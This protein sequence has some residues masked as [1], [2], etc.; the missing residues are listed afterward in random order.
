MCDRIGRWT[1][2]AGALAA[3]C[4]LL[5]GTALGS[6]EPGIL[7]TW[8]IPTPNSLPAGIAVLS[9]GAV[10]FAEAGSDRIGRLEPAT[11][12]ITEWGV[13]DGP[14]GLAVGPGD[15]IYFTERWS[16]RIGRIYPAAGFYASESVA[17]SG[18]QPLGLAI[19]TSAGTTLWWSELSAGKVGRL[20]A[21]GLLFDVLL[22]KVPTSQV[23]PPVTTILS[24]TTTTVFP[25]LVPGNPFL[26]PSI[27]LAPRTGS[28][29]YAEW[30]IPAGGFQLRDLL[31]DAG[32]KI[33]IS[34][35]TTSLLEL[36]PAS[37]T[38]LYHDLP[39][40]SASLK[41][42]RD[43]AGRI[44]F[45]GSWSDKLGRLD[46][47]TG[48][49]ALWSLTPGSQPLALVV[50][51]DG[52]VW[53]TEREGSRIGHLDPAT[54]VLTQY[55]LAPNT[56][57]LSITLDATGAVWFTN[58]W[59]NSVS[60]LAL[61]GVLG[62]PPVWPSLPTAFISIDR[63]C[64]AT[65]H[66]GDPLTLS[67]GASETATFK[68]LDFENT[69]TLKQIATGVVA[70]GATRTTTG[71]V[72][73]PTGLETVVLVARTSSGVWVSSACTFSVGGVSSA[74]VDVS[75]DR[76]P[77]GTYRYGEVT[78]VTLRSAVAGTATLYH[79]NRDGNVTVVTT[80]PIIPTVTQNLTAPIGTT[81]GT[82]TLVLV[83]KAGSQV[84]SAATSYNVV[85]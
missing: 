80:A 29:P 28:W 60:R 75:V 23:V 76:G 70:S 52:S 65:Y 34:T 46:P 63:G 1:R 8:A 11:N 12:R 43:S 41:L 17:A 51:S 77:G 78:T 58:E 7:T 68:L 19:D 66:G 35:E 81:T 13:G 50:A 27:A 61:G 40:G 2:W 74:L 59:G 5:G 25:I 69:G 53:F 48:D 64:G 47:T 9:D 22:P 33:W 3:L 36:D 55:A 4:L 82:S 32:G 83:V 26:P 38:V 18:S 30:T 56:N 31:V 85:P 72:S 14:E 71:T 67:Y 24:P 54:N 15:G 42:A 10:V 37:D 62:P 79:V 57:P 73:G 6:G 49:V 84:L 45:T 21:S 20:T 44:W 39:A 16:D